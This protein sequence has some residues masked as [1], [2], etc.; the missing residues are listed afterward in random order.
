[1]KKF[2]LREPVAA[3][4]VL[5]AVLVLA[6][7][8]GLSLD[9]GQVAALC[10]VAGAVLGMLAATRNVVTPD[11]VAA[12]NVT[13]AAAKAATSVA[14]QLTDTTVGAVGTVT[15]A[16]GAIVSRVVEDVT[17]TITGRKPA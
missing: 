6:V 14:E 8:F 5:Q 4:A 12:A 13:D 7:S 16:G 9:G 11:A 10:G 3:V 15:T 2:L 1:M 17:A